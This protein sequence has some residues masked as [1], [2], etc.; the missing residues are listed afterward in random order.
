MS[1]ELDSTTLPDMLTNAGMEVEDVLHGKQLSNNFLIGKVESVEPHTDSKKLNCCRVNI[2]HE[3]LDIVCGCPTVRSDIFVVVATVGA[4][5]PNG[6]EIKSTKLRGKASNGMICSASELGLTN[7]SKGILIINAECSIGQLANEIIQADDLIYDISLTP[8]R[9]D[10]FSIRGVAREAAA[11]QHD[12]SLPKIK[13]EQPDLAYNKPKLA[14][15]YLLFTIDKPNSETIFKFQRRLISAGYQSQDFWIDFTQYYMHEV[16][17]PMHAFDADKLSGM[18]Y[19]RYA[20][21]GEQIEVLGG[22]TVRLSPDVLVIADD[23]G[24][25]AIAGI[26]GGKRTAVGSNTERVVLEVACFSKDEIAKSCQI[27]GLHTSASDR[28]ARGMDPEL[29]YEMIK[30]IKQNFSEQLVSLNGY[31]DQPE[32][33]KVL[34]EYSEVKRVLGPL[35][36]P[37]ALLKSLLVRSFEVNFSESSALVHIPCFRTDITSAIDVIEEMLRIVGH[38]AWPVSDYTSIVSKPCKQ[39]SSSILSYLLSNSFNEMLTYSFI[40][41]KWLEKISYNIDE[42][43]ILQNPMSGDM[44]VMRPTAILGL[45]DRMSYNNNRQV[46]CGRV[47][48][49]GAVFATVGEVELLTGIVIDDLPKIW[50]ENNVDNFFSIKS[51]LYSFLSSKCSLK[52]KQESGPCWYHPHATSGVY[53]GERKIGYVGLVHPK[54]LANFGLSSVVAFELDWKILLEIEH[55]G[56]IA[57]PI[58][59]FPSSRKDLSFYADSHIRFSHIEDVISCLDIKEISKIELFDI[60]KSDR[61]SYS[62]SLLLQDFEKTLSEDDVS[63]VLEKVVNALENK[64]KLELRGDLCQG[65]QQKQKQT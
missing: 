46:P 62:I 49:K 16:G 15:S 55:P 23:S 65:N 43:L 13:L 1:L 56:N 59:K 12:S 44:S 36:N 63:K 3:V 60:Y 31:L 24:A 52:F 34:V 8:D 9:G 61:I 58:P 7:D 41:P 47:F 14:L 25:I 11:L 29:S 42:N 53:D 20:Q 28:F 30:I 33:I 45:L 57:K 37:E 22:K 38:Q 32:R 21:V 10:C 6:L 35:A 17:Q 51:V 27:L 54:L 48:E 5:M 64:L 26:I 19:V 18:P 39:Y 40:D 4:L 50:S 2:G